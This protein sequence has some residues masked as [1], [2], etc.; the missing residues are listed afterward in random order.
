MLKKNFLS[1]NFSFVRKR[2]IIYKKKKS[3]D[4]GAHC[5]SPLMWGGRGA[6]LWALLF[7][8]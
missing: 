6:R 7:R 2:K 5:P 8:G 1:S 4:N 3:P